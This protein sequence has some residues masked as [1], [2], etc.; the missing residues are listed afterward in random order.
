MFSMKTRWYRFASDEKELNEILGKKECAPLR[1]NSTAVLLVKHQNQYH[2]VKNRC[3]HQ[4]ITLENAYCV[5]GDIVCP[6]HHYGF[7]L[8]NGRGAGLYLDIYPIEKRADGY[9]AGFEKFSL[10]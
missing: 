5:D 3:P 1:I 4:G 7:S 2:L 6:W 9:Y 8:D 10:F